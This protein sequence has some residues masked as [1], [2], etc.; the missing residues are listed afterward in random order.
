LTPTHS[1]KKASTSFLKKRSKKLLFHGILPL[2]AA[3][4]V[5]SQASRPVGKSFL[6]LF[7]KK[8]VLASFLK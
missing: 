7:F 8:E 3:S 6:L 5:A 2:D 4:N 1:R